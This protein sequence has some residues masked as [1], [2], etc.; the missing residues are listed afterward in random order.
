M[1]G[2]Y[3]GREKM[4]G[5]CKKVREGNAGNGKGTEAS[6]AKCKNGMQK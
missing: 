4:K 5:W 3:I 1:G 2:R 6:G